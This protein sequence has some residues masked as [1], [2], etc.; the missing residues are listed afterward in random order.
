VKRLA[1]LSAGPGVFHLLKN[2][3][4][5]ESREEAGSRHWSYAVVAVELMWRWNG[6]HYT[7]WQCPFHL[8]KKRPEVETR[9]D[10]GRPQCVYATAAAVTPCLVREL[11]SMDYSGPR[12]YSII[13]FLQCLPRHATCP[14]SST[15]L[16][17]VRLRLL[18]ARIVSMDWKTGQFLINRSVNL[19]FFNFDFFKKNSLPVY[20][21]TGFDEFQ[22]LSADRFTGF[23]TDL[24]V[25][26]TGKPVRFTDSRLLKYEI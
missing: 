3:R 1:L 21:F 25:I 17:L 8:L 10:A 2:R 4:E 22:P 5:G 7:R 13:R 26:P 11:F 14:S 19:I 15:W 18:H 24:L 16:C 12:K 9:K 20:R 23:G 6:S